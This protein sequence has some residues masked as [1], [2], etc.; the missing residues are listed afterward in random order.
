MMKERVQLIQS[1]ILVSH[2]KHPALS[3]PSG[4]PTEWL[5]EL[6]HVTEIYCACDP[7][8]AVER[9]LHRERHA[10]HGDARATQEE[11]R[12]QF[13]GLS[14]LGPIGLNRVLTVDT[15]TELDISAIVEW[16]GW[17]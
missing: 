6:P 8:V 15:G 17:C 13:L 7:E 9:F 11:L 10:G 16:L 1:A 2:W 4:T 14:A 12:E 5:F 3:S